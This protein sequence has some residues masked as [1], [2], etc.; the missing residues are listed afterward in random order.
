MD[1]TNYARWSSIYL[2][3][4]LILQQTAPE[5]YNEFLKGYFTVKQSSREKTFLKNDNYELKNHH[6]YYAGK[7][8][9]TEIIVEKM[10]QYICQRV[11]PFM[12]GSQP[13]RNI[14]TQECTSQET[15]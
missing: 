13:L 6:E 3:D 4:M 1:R 11:N 14:V 15:T 2:H 9:Q 12:E 8:N 10:L 7:M 5:L